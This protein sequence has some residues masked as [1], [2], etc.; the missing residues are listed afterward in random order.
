MM[1]NNKTLIKEVDELKDVLSKGDAEIP[2]FW[3]CIW[4]GFCLAIWNVF[5]A[6]ISVRS[7]Y[8][9]V[10]YIFWVLVFPGA[11]GLIILFGIA[12]AR[13]LFLSVPKFFREKSVVYVFL[14]KKLIVYAVVYMMV[15]MLL[16]F[17]NR[18]SYDSPF[19]YAFMILLTTVV[20]GFV[21]NLDFGRYQLSLLTSAINS[22]KVEKLEG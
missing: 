11:I 19:P 3:I 21:M 14:T 1:M 9:D 16:A 17:Y 22:L 6:V 7:E 5:C 13:A 15:V 8:L 2:S 4:P 18:F 12:N 10:K 20:F